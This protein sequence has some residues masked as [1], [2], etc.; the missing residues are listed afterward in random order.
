MWLNNIGSLLWIFNKYLKRRILLWHRIYYK[1]LNFIFLIMVLRYSIAHFISYILSAWTKKVILKSPVCA[2][3][4]HC[5]L[6]ICITW[7]F[8]LY[9]WFKDMIM[10]TSS[11]WLIV[12]NIKNLKCCFNGFFLLVL[13]STCL[14]LEHSLCI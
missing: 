13:L 11:Q 2:S 1:A 8:L 9:N 7:N 4:Y 5:I 6:V 12:F 3:N 10:I 14:I